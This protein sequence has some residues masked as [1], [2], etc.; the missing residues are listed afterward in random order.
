[1]YLTV[2]S[3][4]WVQSRALSRP[5][6]CLQ[7]DA[8]S[9]D[10]SIFWNQTV[11]RKETQRCR[12]LQKQSVDSWPGGRTFD[13]CTE[14]F[15]TSHPVVVDQLIGLHFV[16]RPDGPLGL[17]LH[18][19]VV[20]GLK[21]QTLNESDKMMN[22]NIPI[23]IKVSWCKELTCVCGLACSCAS[24]RTLG[25]MGAVNCTQL[26]LA[27]TQSFAGLL[28]TMNQQWTR[29]T[30]WICNNKTG[31]QL[32]A[33]DSSGSRI[34]K[35]YWKSFDIN[36]WKIWCIIMWHWKNWSV[37]GRV[38]PCPRCLWAKAR[39]HHGEV[40]SLSQSHIEIQTANHICIHIYGQRSCQVFS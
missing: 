15:P 28:R 21:T 33:V 40:D 1:M 38:G 3:Q 5:P 10:S 8:P 11:T 6:T 35:G 30:W 29:L 31:S 18:P 9:R 16:L 37:T 34:Q 19:A 22:N 25:V 14:T 26:V 36:E 27:G 4:C 39:G 7:M 12:K 23:V 17:D 13:R 24:G 32:V 2:A 20:T